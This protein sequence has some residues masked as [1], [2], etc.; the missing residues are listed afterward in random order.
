MAY[1]S[2]AASQQRA[3]D[4]AVQGICFFSIW[5]LEVRNNQSFSPSSTARLGKE[6]RP[7]PV[8]RIRSSK[9]Q[10]KQKR[11][12]GKLP[13]PPHPSLPT[14]IHHPPWLQ[15]RTSVLPTQAETCSGT[16][17]LPRRE[18]RQ[19]GA[20]C[21]NGAGLWSEPLRSLDHTPSGQF[22]PVICVVS[23]K[24]GFGFQRLDL[25]GMSCRHTPQLESRVRVTF[26]RC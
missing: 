14:P 22:P 12:H 20:G 3:R 9:V 24:P 7:H 16:A 26:R 15:K 21:G 8:R 4:G 6:F 1:V 25:P 18:R 17:T 23:K 11:V 10:T 2:G 5:S 13:C 19:H